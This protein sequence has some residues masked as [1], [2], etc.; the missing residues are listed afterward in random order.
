MTRLRIWLWCCRSWLVARWL[1]WEADRCEVCLRRDEHGA[2]DADG[3]WVCQ[4][5]WEEE[6]GRER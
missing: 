2:P 6:V 1:D 5:C 3:A 4:E